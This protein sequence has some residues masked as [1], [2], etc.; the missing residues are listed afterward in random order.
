[1]GEGD[2]MVK[3]DGLLPFPAL[4]A[5]EERATAII[6]KAVNEGKTEQATLKALKADAIDVRRLPIRFVGTKIEDSLKAARAAANA[7]RI[8]RKRKASI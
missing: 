6:L 7:L 2:P 8:P 5:L 3:T 4:L 1:M